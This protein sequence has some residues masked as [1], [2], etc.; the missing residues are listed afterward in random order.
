[1]LG[2]SIETIERE[3][4][5]EIDRDRLSRNEG[6]GDDDV[7]ILGLLG[8]QLHFRLNKLLQGYYQHHFNFHMGW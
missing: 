3:K 4:E 7:D 8:K 1:M 2:L 6:G 5:I